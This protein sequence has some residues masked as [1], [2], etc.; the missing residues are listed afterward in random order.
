MR[1]FIVS[2]DSTADIPEDYLN[3]HKIQLH[4]LHYIVNGVEYGTELE[5]GDIPIKEFYEMIEAGTMAT[6]NATNMGYDIQ[7]FEKTA[8]EGY[9]VLHIA[10]ASYMSGS[11]N[12]AKVAAEQVM[13]ENPNCRIVVIDSTKGSG[14]TNLLVRKAV[15]MMEAGKTLDDTAAWIEEAVKR[16]SV[17]FSVPSLMS[18]Y[19]GGRL[20]KSAA[21]LGTIL[22]IQPT[23]YIDE[24]GC[25]TVLNKVRGR[26]AALEFLCETLKPLQEKGTLPK[27]IAIEHGNC[28][29]EAESLGAMA[30]E[31]Y[32]IE[33]IH[34]NF[35]CPTLGSHTGQGII[36]FSFIENEK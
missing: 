32:G 25:L 11:Y 31:R 2:T 13:E 33:K 21:I 12:N 18:L 35:L 10:F 9:D 14:G 4:P 1:P 27:E 29:E 19:R 16:T 15:E 3:E 5:Q 6:T 23:L 7:L 36:T 26:K 20:K 30:K 22:K 17:Y 24:K 8:K 28:L 34:Y